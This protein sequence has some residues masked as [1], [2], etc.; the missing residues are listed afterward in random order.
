MRNTRSSGRC[1]EECRDIVGLL[2]VLNPD[3]PH[4]V[5]EQGVRR[6]ISGLELRGSQPG[7][8][9]PDSSSYSRCEAVRAQ[10]SCDGVQ[11]CKTGEG[12]SCDEAKS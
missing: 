1:A 9:P 5:L 2:T 11:Q 4:R 8:Y 7:P 10:H 12:M 6:V 3:R